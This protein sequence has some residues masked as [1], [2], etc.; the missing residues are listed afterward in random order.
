MRQS[1]CVAGRTS[2]DVQAQPWVQPTNAENGR[3]YSQQEA[4]PHGAAVVSELS[5]AGKP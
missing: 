2:D 5:G 3:M 4:M 1:P